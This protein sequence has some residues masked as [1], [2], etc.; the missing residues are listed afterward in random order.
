MKELLAAAR[1][2][3]FISNRDVASLPRRLAAVGLFPHLCA[4][5]DE[6]VQTRDWR[7]LSS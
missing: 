6:L 3:E 1:D 7:K 5:F 2:A 4:E